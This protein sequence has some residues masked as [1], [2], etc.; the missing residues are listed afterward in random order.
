MSKT[1][2]YLLCILSVPVFSQ[3]YNVTPFTS[4]EGLV[5]SQVWTL[6]QDHNGFLWVG[7]HGGIGK[8]D[9]RQFVNYTLEDS[10]TSDFITCL[11]QDAELN[12]W[13]GTQKGIACYDGHKFFTPG[14]DTS[15]IDVYV[16]DIEEG[17]DGNIWVGT[18]EGLMV[19]DWE[20]WTFN[21]FS[22]Q[23]TE[24]IPDV[25]VI[26]P[27]L[28][29]GMW[30]GTNGGLFQYEQGQI[31]PR[32]LPNMPQG[33]YVMSLL[34]DQ[35]NQL[36]VGTDLGLYVW[37]WENGNLIHFNSFQGHLPDNTIYALTEDAF[38]QI[39]VGTGDGGVIYN[40]GVIISKGW[41]REDQEGIVRAFLSDEEG[42]MWVGTDG[43]GLQK[44]IQGVFTEFDR[45]SGLQSNI[46]KSF[47]EDNEGNI[48][49]SSYDKGIDIYENGK[50]SDHIG[51]GQGLTTNGFYY[52]LK[53][54]EGIIWLASRT[55]G[56]FR[57][58]GEFKAYNKVNGLASSVVYCIS[59][60]NPGEIW[61]GTDKGVS[62]IKNGKISKRLD[63]SS[64]FPNN[65]IYAIRK[66]N[67]GNIWL[68]TPTGVHRMK[69]EKVLTFPPGEGISNPVFSILEDTRGRLWFATSNGLYF[70]D[71]GRFLF[72]R[73]SGARGAHNVVSLAL[74]SDSLLWIG[75]ENGA[76]RLDLSNFRPDRS[77]QF[78]H[79]TLKDG[80]PSM[81]C[82][83]NA[84]FTDSQGNVWIGTT[85]G[86]ALHPS[87]IIP[88]R[89]T[90]KPRIQLTGVRLGSEDTRWEEL[91]YAVEPFS[92]IPR[93]LAL[94]HSSN[95][96]SF[97]W[98]G[99]S[100]KSPKQVE[101]KYRLEGLGEDWSRSTR[102]NETSYS[103]LPSGKYTF[104]VVAKS[105]AERWDYSQP[106][107]FEFEIMAAFYEKAWFWLLVGT[108]LGIVGWL[109][110]RNIAK[111]RERKAEEIRIKDQA[112]KLQLEH[113]ALYAMM[114][115]HF[116]FNALQSI[117]Y[118]VHTSDK[119]SA[120]KFLSSFAKLIRKNLESTKS[121]FISLEEEV[122][123]L[124]LYLSL[125]QMRFPEKFTYDVSVDSELD[126]QSIQIPP[127][128][129]QPFVE[130]SIK[131]GIMPKGKDGNIQVHI[132]P[133]GEEYLRVEIRD[134]G[135]GVEASKIK[136]A[137]RPSEHVS[138]G[139]Q[140]TQDRLALFARM[141]GKKHSL[142]IR[143][144]RDNGHVEG[145]L[146]E[147]IVPL[148]MGEM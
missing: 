7:T 148:E 51:P 129:F 120:N 48:W 97:E 10:L 80:L 17:P 107:T 145:T 61:V 38:G 20:K 65:T 69:E 2:T 76:Y 89:A 127:M 31:Y 147:L 39:W 83:A 98:V 40:Q 70:Y 88:Q 84:L 23:E 141:T 104:Q 62:I 111:E 79:Y 68:G 115:P 77:F 114:N 105:E 50:I 128:I 99:I 21:P 121:E 60:V 11:Y 64:G 26:S 85:G 25:E 57:Y 32:T 96:L 9:G 122:D 63:E 113:Q 93:K 45:Q 46:S 27:D 137:N 143:E 94:P 47:L 42:N 131:H 19:W 135:I 74:E 136:K 90:Q 49:I 140:I 134:N 54:S 56:L 95:R 142:E 100:L 71:S 125:E 3:V 55:A 44:V 59:E 132:S 86:T 112:E 6:L 102:D 146:V 22:W 82:N 75:T 139:M 29:G 118:F 130:N 138:K 53:D 8:Y 67:N 35:Q 4:E 24:D 15:G 13:I 133:H 117:Q 5:Q 108:F 110:Y 116:T 36:W 33:I 123:R 101:Y 126:S 1:L 103:Y 34:E 66:D 18:R 144:I 30:L 12:I 16:Y 37:N 124:R 72:V 73:I 92:N 81:E 78:E 14:K 41:G 91:Q 58:D 119:I 106:A 109:V 28:E 43:R 87:G 52:S